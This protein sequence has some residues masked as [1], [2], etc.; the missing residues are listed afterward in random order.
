LELE[1]I[2]TSIRPLPTAKDAKRG[3][4]YL[5]VAEQPDHRWVAMIGGLNIN[6][7]P[8][9]CPHNHVDWHKS[10]AWENANRAVGM[11]V[12]EWQH[13]VRA[14]VLHDNDYSIRLR[15]PDDSDLG[16]SDCCCCDC[17]P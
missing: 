11:I 13:L 9:T 8:C 3:Q 14:F 4:L 6:P 12:L 5:T 2:D 1:L 7:P 17:G 15:H 16:G 10:K